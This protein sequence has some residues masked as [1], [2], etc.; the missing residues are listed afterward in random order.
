MT[1]FAEI[2]DAKVYL[3]GGAVRDRL[4]GLP[5]YDRDW[6]VVGATAQQMVDAGYQSMPGDFPVFLHPESGDEYALARTEVKTGP[7]YHGFEVDA[8]PD[9]TL[10]Q[11]L[12]RRDLTINA[13]AEDADGNI[14][15]L[16]HGRDDLDEGLLRHITPAF[17]EDPVRLLRIARFT[18]KL[19]QWGF[20]VAHGTHDLMKKMAVSD[21]LLNLKSERVWREMKKALAQPQPWRFFEVLHQCGALQCLLPILGET[22]GDATAHGQSS[23]KAAMAPLHRAVDLTEDLRVRFVAVMFAG[24]ARTG[25]MAEFSRQLPVEREFSDLL[26]WV[27]THGI[28]LDAETPAEN[29]L[30]IVARLKPV[31]QPERFR[32]FEQSCHALWPD[33]VKAAW[34]RLELAQQVVSSVDVQA[35]RRTGLEG[36]ALGDALQHA[37]VEMLRQRLQDL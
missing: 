6:V 16:C 33:K 17:T 1:E 25:E 32:A 28:E 2:S 23:F 18:A 37:R 13:L 26:G 10:E 4:L 27:L 3:V 22:M 34:P 9:I 35:L 12:L 21:D 7:G 19:G 14:I 24:A 29:L 11:D 30:R 15:D 36:A 31:Q 20:R 5:V 8:G